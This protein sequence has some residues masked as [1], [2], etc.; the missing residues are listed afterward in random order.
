M[1][2]VR[3]LNR[4]PP[5]GKRRIVIQQL[6]PILTYGCE[7]YLVPSEQQKRLASEMSRC[8]VGAYRGSRADK[9][10]ALRGVGDLGEVMARKRIRWVESVYG[11]YLPELRE[12]AEPILREISRERGGQ[13]LA[14][15]VERGYPEHR[16]LQSIAIF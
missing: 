2:T 9:V 7:L 15:E 10:Q 13:G 5:R 14:R 11:R 8:I 6:P 3:R 4:L 12:V 16:R 1:E